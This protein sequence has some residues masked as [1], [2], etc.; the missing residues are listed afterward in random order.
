LNTIKIHLSKCGFHTNWFGAI[1]ISIW[2]FT[3]IYKIHIRFLEI[4]RTH[5]C[6]LK[7]SSLVI[8]VSSVQ[9]I[10]GLLYC[11]KDFGLHPG[12]NVRPLKGYYGH[13][14]R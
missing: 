13:F 4:L 3:T 5:W 2:E 14:N 9:F 6:F 12:R 10:E 8:E 1:L 11:T 7:E